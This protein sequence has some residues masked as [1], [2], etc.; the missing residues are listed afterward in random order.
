MACTSGPKIV[1]DGLVFYYDMH[2]T[3]RSWRGAPT[4]NVYP[5]SIT[6][7][8]IDNFLL[9]SSSELAP[10]G[11]YTAKS[12]TIPNISA[13]AQFWYPYGS[14]TLTYTYS[15]WLKSSYNTNVWLYPQGTDENERIMV[16]VTA[17]WQRFSVSRTS[18]SAKTV[19]GLI[20]IFSN[21][22]GILYTWGHQ[23]ENQSFATSYIPTNSG[24]VS[25]SNSQ[26]ILDLTGN[27][28]ITAN[29]LSY[30]N[31][32][33]FSFDGTDEKITITCKASTVRLY[34]STTEF[35]IKLP[36]YA[37]GQRCI[38]S[39]RSGGGGGLYIGK[40]SGGIFSFYNELS[41]PAFTVGSIFDNDVAHVAVIC[42][43]TNNL[44]LHYINGNLAGSANRTGW[45]TNY[46]SSF[47]LG[48]DPGGTNEYM[49]GSMYAFKHYNRV[50]SP[51]EIAQNFEATRSRFNI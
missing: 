3:E 34:N 41:S 23:L 47:V 43:A 36:T 7:Y 14:S 40:Q 10:D 17:E 1:D 24:P 15:V 44:I 2:N 39:Y 51:E 33:I 18:S 48:F 28:A 20:R 35:V 21:F 38:M 6:N 5:N 42:D 11:T 13:Q 27:N 31:N 4:T 50:L 37:G 9:K 45:I 30:D 29:N 26:A 8:G 19:G 16:N 25:R 46:C 32:N 49:V 12:W 22:S